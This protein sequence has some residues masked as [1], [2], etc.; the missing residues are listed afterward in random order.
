MY[1]GIKLEC[2]LTNPEAWANSLGLVGR[3]A[4][5]SG[6]ILPLPSE[7][8]R[9]AC[10]FIKTPT[11]NGDRYTFQGSLHRFHRNGA[12]ND[13]DYTLDEVRETITHLR[14]YYSI[15][16]SRTK[17]HNF[18]F[19]VNI[20]LP[21]GM[22]AQAYQKYLVSANNR[23]FDKLNRRRP[24]VG[25][26]AEFNEFAIKVYDKGYQAQTGATDQIRV[27]IKVNRTR[28]LD[29]FGFNKGKDL[30]FT[31][32]LKPDNIKILG[33]IL[34]NKISSLILTPPLSQVDKRK[35][36]RKQYE[37]FLECSNA[38]SWEDWTSRQRA[39]K[40]AQLA[41]I[42]KKLEQPDP[43]DVLARLVVSKWQEL[44]IKQ[45]EPAGQ[46]TGE[47]VTISNII[48][49]GIRAILDLF[50]MRDNTNH[51][52]TGLSNIEYLPRGKP[53]YF[54]IPPPTRKG[55]RWILNVMC[56]GPPLHNN[57]PG[58]LLPGW[59]QPLIK[60]LTMGKKQKKDEPIWMR[61]YR[62]EV[63]K[64]KEKERLTEQRGRTAASQ[65]GFYQT[66]A[67]HKIRDKRKRN[68][69][70][71]QHCEERGRIKPMQVVDHITPIDEAPDLALD[72][73]NTQSLCNFCHDVKTKADAR[74]KR[75]AERLASGK[76]LM[77]ELE[78]STPQGGRSKTNT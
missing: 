74:K 57:Q 35:L 47:K 9:S 18:E 31:D 60:Y 12:E 66:K 8:N 6:E 39:R 14:K 53:V 72:Y 58:P 40:R 20:K 2:A 4:E 29:Q 38:R 71:C 64:P 70:L 45:V 7:A 49:A 23:S 11:T 22:D 41:T 68:N 48:V 27:E 54:G 30:Y 13:D 69:P 65:S 78:A 28:W 42:F 33:D 62:D 15:D 52:K 24:A 76:K 50:K 67:W 46:N 10:K 61:L 19:G 77:E 16:P 37:T 44:T 21:T 55:Y 51:Y 1:D 75:K 5:Q 56:R 36:S 63:L 3:F 43:V 73:D 26:I 59:F 32:L 34:E 25:Y 17:V